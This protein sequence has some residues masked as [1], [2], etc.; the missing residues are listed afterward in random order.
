MGVGHRTRTRAIFGSPLM[1]T[2][3]TLHQ[4]PFIAEQIFKVV[5][6][7]LHRVGSP[8]PFNAAG[9]GMSAE[10]S[11]KAVLP[12]AALLFDTGTRRGSTHQ[13][14]IPST[15]AFAKGMSTSGE[16]HRFL[17]IHG[18]PQ[19][20]FANVSARSHRVRVAVRPFWV[21]IDETHLNSGKRIF[22]FPISGIA[23][24][25]QPFGLSAP[26][27]VFFGLPNVFAPAPKAAG[28]ESHRLQRAVAS[29]NHQVGPRDF[30]AVFLFDRPQQHTG[31]IEVGVVG[32]AVDR[33]KPLVASACPPATVA[34]AIGASTVPSHAD[35]ERPIVTV[36]SWPPI[37]RRGHQLKDICLQ[38]S[39]VE[40]L[41]SFSVVEG[42]PQ[43]IGL[44]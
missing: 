20:R 6:V 32:P 22:Q 17:V 18:H 13:C 40:A 41:E 34:N 36:V 27:D 29:Q 42:L 10:A 3:R 2:G 7:P 8:C 11:A 39:I 12:A 19:E 28:F 37:L 44:G 21:H 1:G 23:F 38:G 25:P 24:V 14:R 31:F 15:V 35:E 33:G 16:C 9:G 4:F 5:V 43:R 30:L 26:V